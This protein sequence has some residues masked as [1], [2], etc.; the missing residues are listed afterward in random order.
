MKPG[1]R[2][3]YGNPTCGWER[4]CAVEIPER[5]RRGLSYLMLMCKTKSRVVA[6]RL[7]KFV[8]FNRRK[9]ERIFWIS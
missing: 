7:E 4:N 5:E 1:I 3:L 2:T 6:A 8:T 9:L